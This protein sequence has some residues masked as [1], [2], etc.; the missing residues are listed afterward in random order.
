MHARAGSE[1]GDLPPFL[2]RLGR[3]SHDV[4]YDSSCAT[5][6]AALAM[7]EHPTVAALASAGVIEK[8]KGRLKLVRFDEIRL[9]VTPL[10]V[11]RESQR[12]VPQ[13]DDDVASSP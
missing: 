6:H 3:F 13:A 2:Q 1:L 10:Q 9:V 4:G 8:V 5:R 12:R 7:Y 11:P